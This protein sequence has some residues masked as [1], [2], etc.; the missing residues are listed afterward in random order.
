VYSDDGTPQ[1]DTPYSATETGYDVAEVQPSQGDP[2]VAA[3]FVHGVFAVQP[4]ESVSWH[5]ER[6]LTDARLAHS[7]T[8]AVDDY[9]HVLSTA[10]IVY[11]RDPTKNDARTEQTQLWATV[12]EADVADVVTDP[13]WYRHGVPLESRTY[14]ASGFTTPAVGALLSVDAV[15]AAFPYAAPPAAGY[16][17]RLVGRAR[18]RYYDS[19]AL[20]APLPFGQIDPLAMSYESYGLAFTT[21]LVTSLYTGRATDALFTEGGYVHLDDPSDA[22]SQTG[23]WVV[24]GRSLPDPT[25]FYLPTSFSDP[26]GNI[27]SVVYDA[28]KMLVVQVTDPRQN[29]VKAQNDYRV[30]G[31][32]LVTDANGNQSSADVDALGRVVAVR[33][34][35]PPGSG[36]GD[37]APGTPTTTFDYALYDAASGRPSVAHCATRETHGDPATKWQHSYSY[38]DGAGQVVMKKAQAE[39]GLAM[40]KRTDGTYALQPADPRWV[41]NGRTVFDNKGNPVKQYEPY[42]S[43][44]S[45]YE[46]D[47]VLTQWGVTPLLHYDP[48]GRLILTEAPDG[49]TARVVFTPWRQESW[50][51]NDTVLD[52]GNVWYARATASTDPA[53]TRA[54]GLAAK[55]A[56]SPTITRFDSMGRE[57]SVTEDNGTFGQYETTT[58]FDIVGNPLAV[59]DALQRAAMKRDFN[60]L[61][62]AC[63]SLSIDAGERWSLVDVM[64]HPLRHWDGRGQT[65]RTTY[66]ALRR[67]VQAFVLP[68]TGPEILAETTTYGEDYTGGDPATLNLRG[69]VWQ[70]QDGAG[71]AT[72]EAYD[73]KGNLLS[74]TRQCVSDYHVTPDWS[75]PQTLG[76]V[77]RKSTTWDALDRPVTMTTPDG[78]VVRPTYNEATLLETLGVNVSGGATPTPFVGNIDYN[79]KGQRTAIVYGDAKAPAATTGYTYDP[80]TFRLASLATT[81][82]SGP[83]LQQL[84]YTYDPVANIVQIGDAVQQ[85]VFFAGTVVDGT[86]TY[87]YEPIYRLSKA[88]GREQPGGVADAARTDVD[89]P[90]QPIPHPN[91]GQALRPY[92]EQYTYD[93][94]GNMQQIAHT[95][96]G[97]AIGSWNSP[98][99]Y[100]PASNRLTAT[101][102]QGDSPSGPFHALYKYDPHGNMTAMPHLSQIDWDWKDQMQDANLGGGGTVYF[103][104]DSAGQ[105]VR[106]VWEHNGLIDETIYLGGYEVY[107]RHQ[108]GGVVLERQTLHIMD[109]TRRIAMVETKTVDTS[110]SA[111]TPSPVTRFQLGNHL[112][113]VA[114]EMDLQGNLISYEEY[115]PF[116][117]SAYRAANS[118]FDVSLK[119]YRYTSK[120]R[121]EETSLEYHGARYYA[122]WLARWTATD[123]AGIAEGVD[124]YL[125]VRENPIVLHDPDGRQPRRRRHGPTPPPAPAPARRPGSARGR[126]RPAARHIQTQAEIQVAL[127]AGDPQAGWPRLPQVGS[128]VGPE[129]S[130]KT[131]AFD[132]YFRQALDAQVKQQLGGRYAGPITP[133]IGDEGRAANNILFKM[134]PGRVLIGSG[135]SAVPS[136]K[137]AAGFTREA[138]LWKGSAE[139]LGKEFNLPPAVVLALMVRESRMGSIL[140]RFGN[141][142]GTGDHNN[143]IAAM[144]VDKRFHTIVPG[145]PYSGAHLRQALGILAGFA[146]A[147]RTS[148]P[149]WKAEEILAGALD[150]FNAGNAGI[151]T[152]PTDVAHWTQMDRGTASNNY[153]RDVWA[154]ARFY[155]GAVWGDPRGIPST[156][157]VFLP[158]PLP[159]L[160]NS[161]GAAS[162][163]TP[164][165]PK[166]PFQLNTPVPML[167]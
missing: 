161:G 163:A 17:K 13:T 117:T 137:V 94:V 72:S 121:D 33:V 42:F 113:S 7:I 56:G 123:P 109:G 118:A 126:A 129:A 10:S 81:R 103:T 116:G 51:A 44:T 19:K 111:L 53:V 63:H 87:E 70:N 138:R 150:A 67:P 41:G 146:T 55:H 65:L 112:G 153:S 18:T 155:A 127:H 85:P 23:W 29:V 57:F 147:L 30:M 90:V 59:T 133:P 158:P 120:E 151:R 130:Y 4:R 148:H 27:T 78:S 141:D 136:E 132:A 38:S 134:D 76:E 14:E 115:H 79:E 61:S 52:P 37:P 2:N 5:Y 135:R 100:D 77:F 93:S 54:A 96:I 24:T 152:R 91:D 124:L 28:Y 83:A 165:T 58:T 88:T 84:S 35:G 122:P 73:F 82:T 119:R 101:M 97:S 145:G 157:G 69:R 25:Q 102:A 50:D 92:L 8:I 40:Q 167:F 6:D 64:G 49:S 95:A 60:L 47:D 20:P 140:G 162:P 16:T 139:E 32:S 104:Y 131:A 62:Q 80:L 166:P 114:I 110:V 75:Q 125:Y 68:A 106:K 12:S 45:D 160:T 154:M 46:T 107:R 156:R 9:G 159:S 128:P 66:D 89:I 105:R 71:L 21:D 98:F 74:S 22:D 108:G 15:R 86:A 31:P 39:P 1:A 149:D 11:G 3:T 143:G 164:A 26:F 43:A 34:M 99:Q 144:Q 36:Q 48:L 142:P